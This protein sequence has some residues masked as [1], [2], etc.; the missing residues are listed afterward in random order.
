M[1]PRAL[2]F[3]KA[4]LVDNAAALIARAGRTASLGARY[5]AVAREQ[6]ARAAGA[7]PGMAADAVDRL[8]DRIATAHGQPRFTELAAAA[9]AAHTPPALLAAARALSTWKDA[10]ARDRR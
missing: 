6:A 5:A 10:L 4:A 1:P 9:G 8:L 2:A 7:P 3:G